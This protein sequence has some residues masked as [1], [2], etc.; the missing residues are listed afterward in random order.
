MFSS[1][2]ATGEE[3]LDGAERTAGARREEGGFSAGEAMAEEHQAKDGVHQVEDARVVAPPLADGVPEGQAKEGNV[4]TDGVAGQEGVE[5]RAPG[6]G[7]DGA[8][9]VLAGAEAGGVAAHGDL[10]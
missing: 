4:L 9:K 10:Q 1:G 6:V 7:N 3:A 5:G 2:G 8:V